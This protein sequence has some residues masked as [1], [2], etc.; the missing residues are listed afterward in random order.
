MG[1]RVKC[2]IRNDAKFSQLL[3]IFGSMYS[4]HGSRNLNRRKACKVRFKF[5]PKIVQTAAP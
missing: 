3:R 4:I 2:A 1:S 5:A